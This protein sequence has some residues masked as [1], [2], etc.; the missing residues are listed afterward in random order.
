ME[1]TS[2][3]IPTAHLLHLA[4]WVEAAEANGTNPQH[5]VGELLA[6]HELLRTLLVAAKKEAQRLAKRNLRPEFWGP[7]ADFI[8]N[9]GLLFHHRKKNQVLY[10][11][12]QKLGLGSAISAIEPDQQREIETTLE[13]CGAVQ[14]DDWEQTLRLV[15]VFLT[16]KRRN[17]ER[18]ELTILLPA[19]EQHADVLLDLRKRF[20]ALEEKSLFGRKRSDFLAAVR[21]CCRLAGA[22]DPT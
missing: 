4:D 2:D 11:A 9:Y 8:G 13:L 15:S 21:T 17:I 14:E 20:D 22:P 6:E 12:L 1:Q 5:P 19:Y 7:A 10:P 18:E 3:L 16:L